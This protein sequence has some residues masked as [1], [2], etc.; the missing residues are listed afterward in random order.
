DLL[1]E[2]VDPL[3]DR[4]AL[5]ERRRERG[6]VA[7]EAD[8]LLGDVAALGEQRH[9]VC[10]PARVELA[11]ADQAHEAFLH[12]P[13]K[14][15]QGLRQTAP[16][17]G[18]Q[19]PQMGR[20]APHVALEVGAFAAALGVEGPKCRPERPLERRPLAPEVGGLLAQPRRTSRASSSAPTVAV[21]ILPTTTPAAWLASTVASSS[22]PPAPSARAQVAS[23]VSP[24]PVTSK[25][26]RATVGNSSTITPCA[27][28]LKSA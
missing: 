21:P 9:L 23:T 4:P 19:R 7:L 15:G 22:V 13:A 3:A 1:D 14:R 5:A 11:A 12:L 26:S 17:A 18:R 16:D 27:P 25:T 10:D 28:G 24:A 20:A 8:Q 6:E 2:E